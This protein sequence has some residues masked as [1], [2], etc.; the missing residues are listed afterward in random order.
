MRSHH[1]N[2]NQAVL[3]QKNRQFKSIAIFFN[4]TDQKGVLHFAIVAFRKAQFIRKREF[5]TVL[6]YALKS[7]IGI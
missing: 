3:L 2:S 4:R 6:I 7:S 5:P 1:L